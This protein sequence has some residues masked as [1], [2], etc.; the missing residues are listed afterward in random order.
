MTFVV[1]VILAV[2]A[3]LVVLGVGYFIA[4]RWLM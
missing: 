2:V 1:F 4:R 3:V